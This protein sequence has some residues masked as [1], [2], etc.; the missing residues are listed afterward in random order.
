[1]ASQ[2]PEPPAAPPEL[3]EEARVGGTPSGRA[4]NAALVALSRTARSFLLYDPRNDAIRAYI[5]DY[6]SKMADALRAAAGLILDV[7][8][9]DMALGDEVVYLERDRERSLAFR[10]YR[11]GVRR[12]SIRA[13]APWEDL[14]RLLE[15]LSIRYTAVR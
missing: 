5:E 10:M 2:P 13:D 4:A 9:F 15:I 7:R 1:M 11:D 3:V 8:P 12:L 14:L 6:R